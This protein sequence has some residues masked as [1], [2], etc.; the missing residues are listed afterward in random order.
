MEAWKGVE[1]EAQKVARM[2]VGVGRAQ[3]G[4]EGAERREERRFGAE[5]RDVV[6]LGQEGVETGADYARAVDEV[7]KREV[8]EV[9]RQE[10]RRGGRD[11]FGRK[12]AVAVEALG[13]GVA[14]NLVVEDL[15]KAVA[16]RVD[17]D[18]GVA[19]AREGAAARFAASSAKCAVA[20]R[21]SAAVEV[22]EALLHLVA[23]RRAL[24]RAAESVGRQ[25]LRS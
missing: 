6:L 2:C 7:V 9:A 21:L 10:V 19:R 16:D 24:A 23:A 11:E 22:E 1:E 4:V 8:R 3:P 25:T 13:A 5:A 12:N 14:Q 17:G 20:V 18:W 15:D